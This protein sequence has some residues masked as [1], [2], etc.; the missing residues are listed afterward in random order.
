[1][2]TSAKRIARNTL[3]MY[4]RLLVTVPLALYTSRILL[5]QLG[6]DDFGI[7]SAVGGI[8]SLFAVLRGAFSSSTQRFYNYA[9]ASEDARQLSQMY[10]TSLVVH[11]GICV[12]LVGLVECFGLWFIPNKMSFPPAQEGDVYFV[13]QTTVITLVFIVMNI[14]FDGM[15]VAKE[16][17]GFYA[18]ITI[19]DA[20]VKLAL[21]FILIFVDANKLRLYAIFQLCVSAATFFI[22][23]G[24]CRVKFREVKFVGFHQG[25]FKDMA[26][27]AGWGLLGNIC[28]S[29]VTEGT[30]L[31]LNVFG[32][33]VANA[34][35][36]ISYQVRNTLNSVVSNTF[37]ASRPQG[38]QLYAQGDFEN[39]Y[40][41]VFI[42]SKIMFGVSLL[43]V[44]P[45]FC[46]THEVL[47]LWLGEVPEYAV[48]FLKLLLVY[49]LVRAFH[50]PLDLV[51]KASGRMKQYQITTVCIS[52]LTFFLSWVLLACGSPVYIVF[53]VSILV[54][55]LLVGALVRLAERDRL[56][57]RKYCLNVTLPS[58]FML[59]GSIVAAGVV[60]WVHLHFVIGTLLILAT[61]MTAILFLGLSSNER[62]TLIF[63]FFPKLATKFKFLS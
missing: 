53:V 8:V 57:V 11:L 22:T 9:I 15:I 52:S 4:L 61:T 26:T 45:L 54:E 59:V 37:I 38:T 5:Q 17:M 58:I 3:F 1:M 56:N 14:P 28:Y 63:K 31:L 16:R 27:F 62:R 43:M 42:G 35:R 10:S 49:T 60:Y 25:L 7:Y 2:A 18:G 39:F 50:E 32:G 55:V 33:V 24:F 21:V 12:A 48:I 30:N 34:A 13:F 41:I 6:V 36:G 51:F 40:K 46:Y 44:L 23:L 29:L 47:Q 19:W 20:V